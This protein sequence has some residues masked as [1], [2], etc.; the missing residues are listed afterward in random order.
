MSDISSKPFS[1][2]RRF[3]STRRSFWRD[4][5]FRGEFELKILAKY[6]TKENTA[7]DVGGNIGTYS[8]HLSRLARK[9]VTF[10]P[11]PEYVDTIVRLGLPNVSVEQVALSNASGEINLRIPIA[12]GG[13]ADR[14]MASVSAEA[15]PD[16]SLSRIIE[17]PMKRL[18]DYQIA[19]VGFIKIDVEGHEEGVLAGAWDTI[20]R[21]RPALL[22]EIEERHNQ[23][24]IKRIS[25]LL[26]TI[27][28]EGFFFHHGKQFPIKQFVELVHQ[29]ADL[30]WDKNKYDRRTFPYVNNFLFVSTER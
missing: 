25:D 2:L 7:I 10:E 1:R 14:G 4:Y 17:V 5:Y 16:T 13:N 8:Y 30:I 29:P 11:N 27:G 18:D 9:V 28:Y 24:G 3:L 23:G 6:I 12:A 26:A 15:V 20:A 19:D 21:D 22:I